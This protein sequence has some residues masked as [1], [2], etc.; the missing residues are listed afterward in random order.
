MRKRSR[1]RRGRP[2]TIRQK[3]VTVRSAA[4]STV[5]TP[6]LASTRSRC[7]YARGYQRSN[8]HSRDAGGDAPVDHDPPNAQVGF[9]QPSTVGSTSRTRIVAVAAC[10][11]FMRTDHRG[12]VRNARARTDCT[13]LIPYESERSEPLVR[14]FCFWRCDI[15]CSLIF[16]Y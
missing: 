11:T 14:S 10:W 16:L 6:T 8:L 15:F 1:Y 2:V 4:T 7:T 13:I 9:S 3:I 12:Y 5:S